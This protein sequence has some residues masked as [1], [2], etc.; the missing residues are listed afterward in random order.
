MFLIGLSV[1]IG[2][3]SAARSF[4]IPYDCQFRDIIIIYIY[5]LIA[6]NASLSVGVMD[7][8]R[9]CLFPGCI[10]LRIIRLIC[11]GDFCIIRV[12]IKKI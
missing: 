8:I 9:K 2:D 10:C 12:L 1:G 6:C 4:A 11:L 7:I 5:K 3:D